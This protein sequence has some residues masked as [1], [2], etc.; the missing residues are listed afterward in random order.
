MLIGKLTA[1]AS[2]ILG[3]FVLASL[4]TAL[5]LS[6]QSSSYMFDTMTDHMN[7]Y[8]QRQDSM[9]VINKLQTTYEC[10]GVSLWLDWARVSLGVPVGKKSIIFY[11]RIY[12]KALSSR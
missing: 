10:C 12:L 9:D 11:E 1:I 5:A 4:I 8:A 6:G 3:I 2:F 7:R